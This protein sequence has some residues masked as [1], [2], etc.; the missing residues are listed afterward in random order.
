MKLFFYNEEINAARI[1]LINAVR[2]VK[3]FT[4]SC[5]DQQIIKLLS[6]VLKTPGALQEPGDDRELWNAVRRRL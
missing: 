5:D 3:E 1:G 2:E 4:D 6:A